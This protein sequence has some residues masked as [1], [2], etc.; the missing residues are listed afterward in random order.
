VNVTLGGGG[1]R[2]PEKSGTEKLGLYDFF[3]YFVYAQTGSA[4]TQLVRCANPE[5]AGSKG[6]SKA[7]KMLRWAAGCLLQKIQQA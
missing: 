2:K 5:V 7:G 3:G 1:S 6:A 4:D